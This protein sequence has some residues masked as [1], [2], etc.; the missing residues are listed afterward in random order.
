MIVI[1]SLTEQNSRSWLVLFI[2]HVI[3][4]LRAGDFVF[5]HVCIMTVVTVADN[6]HYSFVFSLL[7]GELG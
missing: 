7:Q 5:H 4:C 6:C 3:G 2:C 1:V